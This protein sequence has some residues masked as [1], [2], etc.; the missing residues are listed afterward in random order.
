LRVGIVHGGANVR[1]L[2]AKMK[3]GEESAKLDFV[4]VMACPGGCIGGGGQPKSIDP[5]IRQK[6]IEA[7]YALDKGN[8]LRESHDNPS[9][10]H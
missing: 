8:K 3:A 2:L 5:D 9:V 10:S 6:R 4:E 7:I 1:E